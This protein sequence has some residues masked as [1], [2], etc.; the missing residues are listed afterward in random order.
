MEY[1]K[2]RVDRIRTRVS[3]DREDLIRDSRRKIAEAASALFRKKGFHQTSTADIAKEIGVSQGHL[4]QYILKKQDI[5]LLM[6]EIAAEEYVEKLFSIPLRA[7]SALDKLKLAITEY[8]KILDVHH[9]TTSALYSHGVDLDSKDR[10]ILDNV[11]V[12][13]TTLFKTI[14][15]Q[16]V[17]NG[18]F[19]ELDTFV[20]AFNIVSL[21]HM[22]ALKRNR[23]RGSLNVDGY[24]ETQTRFVLTILNRR[25]IPAKSEKPSRPAI[26]K[27]QA[28]ATAKS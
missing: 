28:R 22:W 8:Y 5:L 1:L 23:F 25:S 27:K 17:A 6:L 7:D 3:D 11:E 19:D 15:D 9:N 12:D 14:L 2:A 26:D 4:Y 16:G 10:R 18:E 21:G 20:L 24:I 13:V